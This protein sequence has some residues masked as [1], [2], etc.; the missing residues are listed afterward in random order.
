MS[1]KVDGSLW[2]TVGGVCVLKHP[3]WHNHVWCKQG[4]RV[5]TYLCILPTAD[6]SPPVRHI[7]AIRMTEQP[8]VLFH[9]EGTRVLAYCAIHIM[10]N[11]GLI[12]IH[13]HLVEPGTRFSEEHSR[14][15]LKVQSDISDR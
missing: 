3:I 14:C 10:E 5:S 13:M 9:Q 7:D 12:P 8:V 11:S 6:G 4:M 15:D 2:Q 1:G